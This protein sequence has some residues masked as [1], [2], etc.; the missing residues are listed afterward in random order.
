M[1]SSGAIAAAPNPLP[2]PSVTC[3]PHSHGANWRISFFAL[4]K[5]ND[6]GVPILKTAKAEVRKANVTDSA[7]CS[8]RQTRRYRNRK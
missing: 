1:A 8:G 2:V 6:P 5:D 3:R 4:L 7:H